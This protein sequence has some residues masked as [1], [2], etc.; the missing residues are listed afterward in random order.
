GAFLANRIRTR[1]LHQHV[2][3]PPA[4]SVL[5]VG[6]TG[7]RGVIALAAAIALPQ[8]LEDGSPFLQRNLIIFLAFSVILV[9]LVLQGLT[10]PWL[11]R[12]LGV[13][14]E[15]SR[16]VEEE[17]ARR[18]IL[19]TA[20]AYLEEESRTQDGSELALFYDDLRGHYRQR[21]G[22]VTGL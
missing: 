8:V 11:V 7:M 14:G 18:E 2:D 5:I 22:A 10:L 6:W 21:L 12:L 3:M 16:N 20:L 19:E 17:A 9:T 1:I 15:P 13:G 4:R